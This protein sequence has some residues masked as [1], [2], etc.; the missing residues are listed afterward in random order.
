MTMNFETPEGYFRLRLQKRYGNKWHAV[1][2]PTAVELRTAL[3]ANLATIEPFLSELVQLSSD[4]DRERRPAVCAPAQVGDDLGVMNPVPSPAGEARHGDLQTE[5]Q[6]GEATI[7]A[8]P[9]WP[10]GAFVKELEQLINRHSMENGSDTPDFLLAEYLRGCL[11]V[12]DRTVRQR[13]QWYGRRSRTEPRIG[14]Y[15]DLTVG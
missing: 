6:A 4:R 12:Y 10:D 15:R 11:D 8:A 14:E 1:G 9:A 2:W 5:G 3:V 7:P 13:E